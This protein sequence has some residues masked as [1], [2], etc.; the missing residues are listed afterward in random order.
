MKMSAT[1]MDLKQKRLLLLVLVVGEMRNGRNW[2]T[3]MMTIATLWTL[4]DRQDLARKHDHLSYDSLLRKSNPWHLLWRFRNSPI[5]VTLI[6]FPL[7]RLCSKVL[8]NALRRRR[9]LNSMFG[10][11]N[12][13]TNRLNIIT[14]LPVISPSALSPKPLGALDQIYSQI[15]SMSLEKQRTLDILGALIAMRASSKLFLDWSP[16]VELLRVAEKLLDL[17]P[18]DGPQALRMIHSLVYITGDP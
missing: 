14:S 4:S 2:S 15:L 1:H 12:Y 7:T 8:I 18:G 3:S 13:P 11:P 16:H 17:Q 5:L 6:I 10:D 9:R